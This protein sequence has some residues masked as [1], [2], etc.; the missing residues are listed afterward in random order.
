MA[1]C[2]FY[3]VI[4]DEAVSSK[5]EQQTGKRNKR[6]KWCIGR[7]GLTEEP[8]CECNV[9]LKRDLRVK[10]KVQWRLAVVL[11]V[12]VV[13]LLLKWEWENLKTATGHENAAV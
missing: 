3:S 8:K 7:F 11:P 13:K 10:Q 6:S 1:G 5:N 2:P 12:V 9:S 4:W